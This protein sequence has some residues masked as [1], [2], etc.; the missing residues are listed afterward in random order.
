MP[1]K[2]PRLSVIIPCHNGAATLAQQ[3]EAL[4]RQQF[5]KASEGAW[6]G[7]WEVIVVNNGST[8]R[9]V[10][11]AE[12]Y[13]DRLP[14]LTI[15]E[16]HQ[17]GTPLLGVTH[18]YNVGLQAAQGDA[19]AFCEADDEVC[20]HWVQAV[21]SALQQHE[22]IAGSLCH[23]Q[24]NE[25]W[26][27]EAFGAGSQMEQLPR[28]YLIEKYVYASGCNLAFRRSVYDKLGPI[29]ESIRYVWDMEFCW[30][31]QDLGIAMVFVPEMAIQYRLPTK[32]PKIYNRVR[33]W[34]IE[35]AELQ[36]RYQGR[37]SAI[38]LLK[39]NYWTLKYSALSAFC[40]LRYSMGGSKAKLAQSLHELGGCVGRFQ[41]TFYL[42]RV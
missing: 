39:L 9:S 18:S 37:N 22:L 12:G 34:C 31:A 3:L 8:D 14:R 20:D 28:F 41:G 10:E 24:L 21:G 30:K 11:I 7:E 23:D 13:R 16:A 2:P 33:L 35:T 19:F 27:I 5:D 32:L 29:D 25:A 1:L 6:Q 26:Q 17:P 40:W 42:S 15:A 36:R 4:A 38:A